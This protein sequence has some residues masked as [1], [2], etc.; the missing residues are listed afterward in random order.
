MS[1]LSHPIWHS[2]LWWLSLAFFVTGMVGSWLFLLRHKTKIKLEQRVETYFEQ[3]HNHGLSQDEL[4]SDQQA[5]SKEVAKLKQ[6]LHNAGFFQNQAVRYLVVAKIGLAL[7]CAS[8]LFIS[9]SIN[10]SLSVQDGLIIAALAFMAN[11]M[12]DYYLKHLAQ[13]RQKQILGALPDSLDLIAICL[14]SG[15]TFERSLTMVS[16][17]LLDVYPVLAEEW[18]QTLRQLSLNPDRQVAFD[19]LVQRCP[20]PEMSALV[21][22]VKQAEKFGSPLAQTFKNF[23][24]E[25]RE[26]SKLTLD[27]NV[28]K[29]S[30]KITL[31]MLV[32]VFLPL[33]VIILAPIGFQ[34]LTALQELG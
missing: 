2:Q 15:A 8:V 20:S 22:A 24:G 12:P 34:L 6:M 10:K 19:G 30:T 4:F 3:K 11:L 28:G 27:E 18:Q 7:L 5:D 17:H 23:A 29:L 16:E 25:M 1:W 32:L 9:L 14:E 13:N 26:L 33:L 21:A 31:P